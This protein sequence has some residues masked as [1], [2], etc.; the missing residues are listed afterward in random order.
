MDGVNKDEREIPV[1]Q[2]LLEGAQEIAAIR[3]LHF[4]LIL[5]LENLALND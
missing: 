1:F 5:V 3:F 2:R 4:W